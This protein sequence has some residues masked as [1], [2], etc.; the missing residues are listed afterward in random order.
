MAY[1]THITTPLFTP[2]RKVLETMKAAEAVF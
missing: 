2:I 1:S